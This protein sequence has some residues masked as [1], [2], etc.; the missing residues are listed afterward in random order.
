MQ[1]TDWMSRTRSARLS[2]GGEGLL[3]KFGIR[4]GGL[5]PGRVEYEVQAFLELMD[6][7]YLSDQTDAGRNA[8]FLTVASLLLFTRWGDHGEGAEAVVVTPRSS[9]MER[10]TS[11]AFEHLSSAN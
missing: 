1:T 3:P 2:Q 5:P 9:C 7:D 6:V 8:P 4:E 10:W 11:L